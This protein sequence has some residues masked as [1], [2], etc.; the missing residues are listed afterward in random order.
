MA[1]NVWERCH[2]RYQ[3][4]LGPSAVVDPWGSA[5]GSEHATRGGSWSYYPHV[6]RAAVRGH[7]LPEVRNNYLGFRCCRSM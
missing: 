3:A 2:D 1:G 7:D 4:D 5:N 6:L